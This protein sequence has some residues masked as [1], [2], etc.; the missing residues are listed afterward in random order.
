MQ[1]RTLGTQGL[2]TSA[3]GYG[4]M[5][6]SLAYG[7][8]DEQEGIAAIQKAHELGVTF[9]DTA[10]LYGW[11]ANE[12]IV[13]RA[14]KS[15]RDEVVIATKFGFTRDGGFDSRPEHIRDVV[16]NSLSRLGVDHIDVLYQHRVD[17]S[18]PIEDVAG[19][20][21]EFID[22]GKVKYFGLSEAGPETLRRAH[23]V[24][25]VSVLQTE[26]SLF[27]RDVEVLFPVLN[28][29]GIGFVPYSP[30]GRGFLTGTAKPAAEYDETDMRSWDARW[31]PGNFEKNVEA[32]RQ[33]TELAA[34]KDATVAQLALAWLLAQGEHIV[35]IPGTR[36]AK[37]VEENVG[38]V[39]L[40]LT[41]A[42]LARIA[43]ILPTGG[44]GSRYPEE[45]SP[46]WQ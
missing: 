13:G 36:S 28:E 40:S 5:G 30:L 8:S 23:A 6:I 33:L 20:V 46:T 4:S 41:D 22:A 37:R 14:V 3:I 32:T 24:Q 35:P 25:P 12:E 17:P 26:Y 9:F 18:V 43:E 34:S 2:T 42:D 21:K 44:F 1:T 10:E 19:T 15:F 16:E 39:D 29:L 45:M 7:P 11:G 31:Q 27:E 38:A